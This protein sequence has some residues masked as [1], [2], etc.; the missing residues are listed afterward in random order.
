M[1]GY[2]CND[3][4]WHGPAPASTTVAIGGRPS[5]VMDVCPE[6]FEVESTLSMCCDEPGCNNDICAGTPYPGGYKKHCHEHPPMAEK[7]KS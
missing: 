7:G 4:G 6:C 2:K 1:S 3:C 5:F